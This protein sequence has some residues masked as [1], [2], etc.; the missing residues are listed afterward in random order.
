MGWEK[1]IQNC[2]KSMSLKKWVGTNTLYSRYMQQGH[3][4]IKILILIFHQISNM[5]SNSNN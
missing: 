3:C 1:F 4:K 2:P 5:I